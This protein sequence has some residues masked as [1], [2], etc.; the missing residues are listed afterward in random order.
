MSDSGKICFLLTVT[1]I[2]LMFCFLPAFSTLISATCLPLIPLFQTLPLL[3]VAHVG[4]FFLFIMTFCV[5]CV[6]QVVCIKAKVTGNVTLGFITPTNGV[7]EML[8]CKV[9]A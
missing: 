5:K 7:A 2:L 8:E 4:S 3:A 6:S 1:L 9:T